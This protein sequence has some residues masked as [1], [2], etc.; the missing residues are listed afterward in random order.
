[1]SQPGHEPTWISPGE[2]GKFHGGDTRVTDY[3]GN[4]PETNRND[5]RSSERDCHRS[6]SP[7]L[8]V[9]LGQPELAVAQ[10]LGATDHFGEVRRCGRCPY[11]YSQ[12]GHAG[13]LD[14]LVVLAVVCLAVT[15]RALL[16]AGGK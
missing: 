1:M 14:L 3:S 6:N 5:L 7:E 16:I 12:L 10:L 4:H 11:L 15:V 8:E 9:V 13:L 2:G